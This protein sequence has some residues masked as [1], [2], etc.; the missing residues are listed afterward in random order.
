[1]TDVPQYLQVPTP[2][3][4]TYGRLERKDDYYLIDTPHP[5]VREMAKRVF[6]GCAR[7]SMLKFKATRRAVADL[8]WLLMRFPLEILNPEHYEADRHRAVA[9]ALRRESCQQLDPATP[10]ATFNGELMPFQAVGVSYLLANERCLLADDMG[11]GKTVT[12]LAG[13]ATGSLWPAVI[14]V[15]ANVQRQWRR[16]IGAFLRIVPDG[17]LFADPTGQEVA[18][19]LK[20]L[21]PYKLP[22]RHIYIIH[23][24]LLR[25]WRDA[26]LELKPKAVIFDEVQELRHTGTIKYSVAS[27]LAGAADKVWG[28]SGTPIYNYGGEIWSVLN[29]LDYHCLGD[30]DSFSREW[31]SGYGTSIVAKPDVLSDYLLREG[32]MLRRLKKDVQDQLPPKRRVVITI[33]HDEDVYARL[34]AETRQLATQYEQ[35]QDWHAK[36][37][38]ALQIDGSSRRAT[39]VSKAPHVGAFIRTLLEAGEKPLIYAWHHDVH[40]AIA[41]ELKDYKLARITGMETQAQKDKAVGDFAAGHV[42]AVQL[43]LRA[44]AGLDG[45]QGRG[46][47]VVFVELDWSP[48]IHAQCEDRLHRLGIGEMES[49]LCYYL[50]SQTGYDGVVMEALGLKVEQFTR[51]MGD[52]PETQDDRDRALEAGRKHMQKLI[53][54]LRSKPAA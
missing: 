31:C 50:V 4:T 6:P 14:V 51:I 48:A 19:I 25:G 3:A 53:E 39:G 41:A 43:S 46:T 18:V 22:R 10:P 20:G 54:C 38:L 12:G 5:S 15:P 24:G 34:I 49:L 44:T 27:E 1:V 11:L 42:D 26:L 36:G 33:D 37:Q 35:T 8:N 45:L 28:L 21:K 9:H 40:D 2:A 29:I 30:Y 7:G 23:Y 47:C 17:E 52:T 32:L 16:Q 13:L